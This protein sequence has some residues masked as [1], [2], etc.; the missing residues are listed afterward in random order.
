MLENNPQS[1]PD[2]LSE[3]DKV[4]KERDNKSLLE[5]LYNF[6]YNKVCVDGIDRYIVEFDFYGPKNLKWIGVSFGIPLSNLQYRKKRLLKK[7]RRI[8]K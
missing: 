1:N 5:K 3:D 8:F 4:W 2:M 6:D 7:L